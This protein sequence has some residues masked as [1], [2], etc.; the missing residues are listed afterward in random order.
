MSGA[1]G[2]GALK[3]IDVYRFAIVV[4]YLKCLSEDSAGKMIY[5][6]ASLVKFKLLIKLLAKGPTSLRESIPISV[7]LSSGDK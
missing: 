1:F 4:A 7:H 6:A 2:C 3:H 5:G